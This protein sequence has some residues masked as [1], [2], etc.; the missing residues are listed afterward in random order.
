ME[1]FR[2]VILTLAYTIGISAI[3][4]QLLCYKKGIEY[5]ETI[6]FSISLLLLIISITIV[7]FY[8]VSGKTPGKYLETSFY[9]FYLLLGVTTPINVHTER[10]V[11]K[12]RQKN[13]IIIV[14]AMILALFS[15]FSFILHYNKPIKIA[16]LAF[17]IVSV[18]YS[19]IVISRE[20]PS[21][22]VHH[23]EKIEKIT[24]RIFIIFFPLYGIL[25]FL[26]YI[27]SFHAETMLDGPIII[28][29]VVIFLAL[30]KLLDDFKR[31]SLFTVDNSCSKDKLSYYNI[32]NRE[33]EVLDLLVKGV[34]Y[35][36]IGEKLFISIPTV[37]THVQSI[38]QKMNINNKVELINLINS[39]SA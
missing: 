34:T 38:Y 37:K 33:T 27:F 4:L 22:L 2:L 5:K 36:D 3:I 21:L 17:L 24:A 16:I 11:N 13:R 14:I 25:I 9:I 1:I 18:V 12:A 6:F 8:E 26:N 19:M 32:T 39:Q 29:F 30:S 28:S 23:R 20:K 15:L 35:K 7:E 31:L 10:I